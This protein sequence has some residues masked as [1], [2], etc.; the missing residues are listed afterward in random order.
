MGGGWDPSTLPQLSLL[1]RLRQPMEWI[2]DLEL[3]WSLGSLESANSGFR[4][5]GS[6][7]GC[8]ERTF[9]TNHKGRTW[10]N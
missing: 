1:S 9:G 4:F 10:K 5:E 6:N 2:L 3:G 8:E 7:E